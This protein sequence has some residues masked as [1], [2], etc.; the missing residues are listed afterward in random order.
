[1]AAD[2]EHPRARLP[3][4]DE[5]DGI[6]HA[7]PEP[8]PAP[9]DLRFRFCNHGYSRDSCVHF[10]SG[11]SRSCTRLTVLN[12]TAECLEIL[13]VDET[14]HAPVSW[15]SV[16]YRPHTGSIEPDLSDACARAQLVAFCKSYLRRFGS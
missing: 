15:R 4:L 16:T 5:Y 9:G 7:T 12:V 3:L 13:S 11:D 8:F 14:D 2:P 6:C 10:P 1:M